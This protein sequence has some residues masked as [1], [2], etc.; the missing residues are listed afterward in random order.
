MAKKIVLICLSVITLISCKRDIINY[1]ASVDLYYLDTISVEK[2]F[3]LESNDIKQEKDIFEINN[4]KL[5]VK[6]CSRIDKLQYLIASNSITLLINL[7]FWKSGKY[8][9]KELEYDQKRPILTKGDTTF[10]FVDNR[11]YYSI[12][13]MTNEV[14]CATIA[15]PDILYNQMVAAYGVYAIRLSNRI[16]VSSDLKNWTQIFD[17][18][19]GILESMVLKANSAKNDIELLWTDYTGGNERERHYVYKYSFNT[20]KSE[21]KHTFYTTQDNKQT[22]ATPFARHIHILSLDPYT[23]DVYLGT[24]DTD[25][26]SA[27]YRSTD[28]GETF[29]R[30]G[31]GAQIWRTLSF[32]YTEK[33]IFWNTDSHQ[34]QY[35][36]RASRMVINQ[37]R[38]LSLDDIVAFP[39]INSA[40][41]NSIKVNV[42]STNSVYV[43]SSSNEGAIVDNWCRTYGIEIN[44]EIPTVY[45]LFKI[46]S[47]SWATQ[48]FLFAKDNEQNIYLCDHEI[49]QIRKFKIILN[50]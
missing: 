3:G 25:E 16:Y 38:E 29:I 26:E 1:D 22:G 27:I 43:M 47:R 28:A 37:N 45:E 21:I 33:S 24:G 49:N 11:L 50:E 2:Y 13:N 4:G 42:S 7:R 40:L 17:K 32:T 10:F 8:S 20:R 12:D 9:L 41:W 34:S 35:L 18:K 5:F 31:G 48:L 23:G 36:T 46:P 14:Y 30:I 6:N 19:R 15:T 44:N 39:L